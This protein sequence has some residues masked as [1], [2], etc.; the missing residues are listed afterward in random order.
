MI[1]F[2]LLI[3]STHF[4][5]DGKVLQT[6]LIIL[7]FHSNSRH[8]S[9]I[10]FLKESKLSSRGNKLKHGRGP[11]QREIERDSADAKA[12]VLALF[13]QSCEAFHYERRS[14]I[15]GKLYYLNLHGIRRLCRRSQSPLLPRHFSRWKNPNTAKKS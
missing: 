15:A 12:S 7:I 8:L 6:R 9:T 3:I 11:L 14:N 1:F 5:R 4:G 2:Y 10:F 13:A